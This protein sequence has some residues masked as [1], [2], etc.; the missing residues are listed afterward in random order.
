MKV[1]LSIML[2]YLFVGELM[3]A[4]MYG[5]VYT[6]VS[7]AAW[8]DCSLG[9][10]KLNQPLASTQKE[11]GKVRLPRSGLSYITAYL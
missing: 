8:H 4:A 9:L 6:F 2:T 7:G 11:G 5:V 10:T 3:A 1:S